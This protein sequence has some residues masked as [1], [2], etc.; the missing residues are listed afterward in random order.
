VSGRSAAVPAPG[1]TTTTP[2]R[3][4]SGLF[5]RRIGLPVALGLVLLVLVVLPTAFMF[6]GSTMSA[7]MADPDAHFTLQKLRL[8]YTTRPYLYALGY[9]L[10]MSGGVAALA[11]VTGIAMG[12]LVA[13]T[14][15]PRKRLLEV[16]LI[17]PLFLSP[18][19]GGTGLDD[20]RVAEVGAAECARA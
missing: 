20:P 7:G 12:W 11:T 15:L 17:A 19:V 10:M 8:V 6:I 14:D 1:L 4:R 18:F 3:V 2:V 9:T 13:R 16:C 5:A